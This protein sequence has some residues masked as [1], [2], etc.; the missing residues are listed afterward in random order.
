MS[1]KRWSTASDWSLWIN[2]S[3]TG[4]LPRIVNSTLRLPFEKAPHIGNGTSSNDFIARWSWGQRQRSEYNQPYLFNA[5]LKNDSDIS[6]PTV[7]ANINHTVISGGTNE[8]SE[9]GYNSMYTDSYL[10][11]NGTDFVYPKSTQAFYISCWIKSH[12][13]DYTEDISIIVSR[14]SNTIPN[15]FFFGIAIYN[16][17]LQGVIISSALRG[18]LQF[19]PPVGGDVAID[20]NWHHLLLACGKTTSSSAE[21]FVVDNNWGSGPQDGVHNIG[22]SISSDAS[23]PLDIGSVKL[24][25]FPAYQGFSGIVDELVISKWEY[26]GNLYSKISDP[27]IDHSAVANFIPNYAPTYRHKSSIFISD[28]IDTGSN[29][30][31]ITGLYTEHSAPNGSSV[32]FSF[33]ASNTIFGSQDSEHTWTG[34]TSPNSISSGSYVGQNMLGVWVRG[35]YQQ[36]RIKMNPSS[37]SSPSSDPLQLETPSMEFLELA[38]GHDNIILG[39]TRPAYETGMIVGQIY[40][41]DGDKKIDKV[42]LELGVND[43]DKQAYIVGNGGTLSFQASNWQESRDDYIFQPVVHWASYNGWETSGTTIQNTFQTTDWAT[44]EDAL[45]NAPYLKYDLYFTEG[46]LYYLWGYGYIDNDGIFYT[47]DDDSTDLRKLNLGTD[48]SG[49]GT[50]P[51]WTKFGSVLLEGGY[52]SFTIYLAQQNTCILDQWLFTTNANIQNDLSQGSYSTPQPISQCPFNTA[53]RLRSVYRGAINALDYPKASPAISVTAWLPS[54]TISATGKFNYA[55]KDSFGMGIT[56]TRG[57]S[58]E[59]WQIGGSS[60]F[61]ASWNYKKTD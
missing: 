53:V 17:T 4:R 54:S 40:N 16:N 47:F 14:H 19:I 18:A 10:S 32:Q 28:V 60:K 30:N 21:I 34:F 26:D 35:R 22:P 48:I 49:W 12:I 29:N 8:M 25:G 6:D 3:S 51:R 41:F 38:T 7:P 15:L 59:Y 61:F 27:L 11:V 33:R 23:Y 13:S 20:T 58:L 55:I 31:L 36:V 24:V 52:H 44:E 57:L 1:I 43:E 50:A 42:S 39:A 46:G 9:Y 37:L 45:A 2:S 56:L 5:D